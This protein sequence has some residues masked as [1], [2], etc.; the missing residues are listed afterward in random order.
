MRCPQLRQ[1]TY[2]WLVDLDNADERSISNQMRR[3][4]HNNYP[5]FLDCDHRALEVVCHESILISTTGWCERV[6]AAANVSCVSP[7]DACSV[8]SSPT[9]GSIISTTS[10]CEGL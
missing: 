8:V 6:A 2:F 1:Q 7:A 10:R 5:G 9:D 4:T 3:G